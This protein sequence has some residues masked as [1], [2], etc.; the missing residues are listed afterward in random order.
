MITTIFLTTFGII[1]GFV[2]G[3]FFTR[4]NLKTVNQVVNVAQIEGKVALNAASASVAEA[5]KI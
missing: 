1:S 4:K 2:F 5:K 3:V